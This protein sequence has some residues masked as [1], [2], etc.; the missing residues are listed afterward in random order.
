MSLVPA[1]HYKVDLTRYRIIGRE[2]ME[3]LPSGTFT[4]RPQVSNGLRTGGGEDDDLGRS[5]SSIIASLPPVSNCTRTGG[6][7]SSPKV[8]GLGTG[9]G[10]WVLID[11]HN[12]ACHQ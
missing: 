1:C 2:N 10:E 4:T 8:N 5:G 7:D 11:T 6:G 9:T 3:A 12:D